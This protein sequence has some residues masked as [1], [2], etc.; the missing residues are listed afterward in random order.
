M[1]DL[2]AIQSSLKSSI[3]RQALYMATFASVL[4]IRLMVS[5]NQ[6][7]GEGYFPVFGDFEAQRHWKELTINHSPKDWYVNYIRD[8]KTN[9][10]PLDYPPLTAYH[11]FTMGLVSRYFHPA[12]VALDTSRGYEEPSHRLFM[13]LTVIVSEMVV[14][15]PAA[16]F[17]SHA[18]VVANRWLKFTT[19]LVL[20]LSP[21]Q[22]FVDHGHFQYNNMAL[23][24]FLF[25]IGF[26]IR[27]RPFMGGFCFTLAFMYKQTLL[28]FSPMFFAF[29]FGEALRL[30]TWGDTLKRVAALGAIVLGTVGVLLTPLVWHCST[31]ACAQTHVGY[32]LTAIFPFGRGVFEG[33]VANA[34]LV[35][36]PIL[37]LRSGLMHSPYLG[38]AST[39]G[40]VLGFLEV[41]W[42]MGRNPKTSLFPVALAATSLAF[43]LFS[44][45]VHEKAIILP[46]TALLAGLPAL[47]DSGNL[48]LVVRMTEAGLISLWELMI[49]DICVMG[50]LPMGIVGLIVLRSVVASLTKKKTPD[51]WQNTVSIGLNLIGVVGMIGA[52][53][54][55]APERYPGLWFWVLSAAS[56]GTFFITWRL[57]IDIVKGK[58]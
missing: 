26:S 18:P 7:S 17:L 53:G 6:Y 49:N 34:W 4:F 14:Y 54:L 47:A 13:R 37:K 29:M 16:Y 12:S 52:V 31:L 56:F 46:L 15:M 50:G 51:S 42:Y 39:G 44:W 30:K 20:L 55:P 2:S 40:T 27:N 22:I 19:F 8:P 35:L 24:F 9:P 38:L 11:E 57:L 1:I 36:S 43:Y 25:A 33:Y 41:C 48:D 5:F 3:P 10:W 28:Y 45:M 23:G 21:T 32:L 58:H